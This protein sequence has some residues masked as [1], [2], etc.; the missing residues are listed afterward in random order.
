MQSHTRW[1][2]GLLS[3]LALGC[4]ASSTNPAALSPAGA[5]LTYGT[6]STYV[7]TGV[8]GYSGDGGAA[9]S[10]QIYQP[11]AL[12]FDPSGNLYLSDGADNVVRKVAAATGVISTYAGSFQGLL[13]GGFSGNGGAA[14]SAH[15]YGPF[16]L[17]LDAVGNLYVSDS[18]NNTIRKVSAESGVISGFAGNAMLHGTARGTY[19]GDGG[20]AINAGINHPF[21]IVFDTSGNLYLCDT[22]NHVVRRVAA[23]TGTMTTVAGTGQAGSSGDGGLATAAQLYNPEGITFDSA[24][25]L[26]LTDQANNT[27]REVNVATGVIT[28]VAGGGTP[29]LSGAGDGGLATQASLRSPQDVAFDAVGDM[30]I[31]DTSNHV[32]RRVKKVTGIIETIVGTMQGYGGDG[33]LASAAKLN[34]PNGLAFDAAGNLYISDGA[35]SRIRKVVVTR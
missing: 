32:I 21:K 3:F 1:I 34:N 24:G 22:E 9:T 33:G 4:G 18:A 23:G 12:V 28:T 29:S 2:A 8:L 27:V 25:N 35:N 6:I 7:G 26:Y 16:G 14:T 5:A 11:Y 13:S 15:F 17:A 30:I 31:A 20:Q 10:A 19:T